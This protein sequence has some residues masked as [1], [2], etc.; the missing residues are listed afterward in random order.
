MGKEAR[1]LKKIGIVI[2]NYNKQDYIIP[3]IHSILN[4]SVN[5]F[6]LFVVDNASTDDSVKL[7]KKEFEGRL[8]LL[9]NKEN[10]GGSGGFNTG[11]KEALKGDYAYL[12]CV[13]NDV[14]FDK[15]AIEEL[16]HF[17]EENSEAG[18]AGSRV[19]FMDDPEYIW[20]YS[21][22]IDFEKY[23]QIDNYRNCKDT[24]EVP[25]VVYGDYVP[26]CALMARTEAVR[27]VGIMPEENFIYWDDMEWGYRFNQA[28]YKVAAVGASRVW[29]KGGGRNA[30]NTFINYYMWRNRIRFFLKVLD[31]QEQ[32]R[33]I[34]TVL[35][36]L[37]R[38]IYSCNLKGESNIVR[39][40][41]YA[42]DDAAHG[43]SGKAEDYKILPRNA[44]K[45]RLREALG[46]AENILIRFNGS[47]EGIG[48]VVRAVRK[49]APEIKITISVPQ[50]YEKQSDQL[51]SQFAQCEVTENYLPEQY[52][53]HLNLC[54]HI[55]KLDRNMPQDNYVDAWCNIIYTPQDFIYA[56]SFEQNR[57]L[58]IL[59][60]KGLLLHAN[61]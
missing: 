23:V 61:P 34:H 36:E 15:Y 35:S 14:V 46:T 41:M 39:T 50:E 53:M 30:G 17:L 16:Y 25:D 13:D 56:S 2:C 18:M 44:E 26:A 1:I 19:Y 8:T 57:E 51:Q 20:S 7:I 28:G 6:D 31:G 10:L 22:D 3:C 32:E 27:K 55:F 29:H 49:T 11:L 24:K 54:E 4:S 21:A 40:V 59:S 48:N 47:F 58:F 45:D 12:M 43:V 37:F 42:L 60:M 9:V 33:F 38:L 5:H 52:G